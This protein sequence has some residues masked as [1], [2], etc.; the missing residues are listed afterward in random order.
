MSETVRAKRNESLQ[1]EFMLISYQFISLNLRRL[2]DDLL[3]LHRGV[4]L[5]GE[6]VRQ[7]NNKTLGQFQIY[8][9]KNYNLVLK[10]TV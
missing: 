7:N 10:H 3:E 2:V 1:D 6:G 5:R 8:I 9:K 4:D